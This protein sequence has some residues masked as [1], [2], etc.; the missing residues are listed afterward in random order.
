[1]P[2]PG[3]EWAAQQLGSPV[4]DARPLVGGIT[5][6]MLALTTGSGERAVLRLMTNE[7]WRTHGAALT[8]REHETQLMLADTDVP[9][10][11]SIALDADGVH[12]G[13]AA[14]LMTLLPGAVDQGRVS[15][16]DLEVVAR[17]LVT[18]HAM[19]PA[20]RPRSYQSWAYPAK[21]VVPE[22]A[23]EPAAWERAFA[24]LGQDP[25]AYD[26]TFLHR[27]F[28]PRNLLWTGDTITG[29]VD[30]VETSWGPA[31]L[32]VAHFRTMLAVTHGTPVADR[33]GAT[34]ERL[35]GRRAQPYFDVMDVVGLLPAPGRQPFLRDAGD[36]ARLESHLLS[37]L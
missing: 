29:I 12:A 15:E 35:T 6:T 36:R 24:I 5:S 14:H 26:G 13:E 19:R 25:P 21:Y 22:W 10:P 16:A 23:R 9:A 20:T 4:V 2:D 31:W 30:W 11:R 8:T 1:M 7:P 18:I 37:L 32:D 17:A 34:Y 28:A 33:F 27:D 3:L